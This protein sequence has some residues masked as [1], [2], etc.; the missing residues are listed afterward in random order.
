M[1]FIAVGTR[2]LRNDKTQKP[3]RQIL[4]IDHA[5]SAACAERAPQDITTEKLTDTINHN[6]TNLKFPDCVRPTRMRIIDPTPRGT[7]IA[8]R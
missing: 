6:L 3:N 4:P 5:R 1:T 8:N 7:G 2:R